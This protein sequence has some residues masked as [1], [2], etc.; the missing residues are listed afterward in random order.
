LPLPVNTRL[1]RTAGQIQAQ[2]IRPNKITESTINATENHHCG[3]S[4]LAARAL[5]RYPRGQVKVIGNRQTPRGWSRNPIESAAEMIQI[6]REQRPPYL[7]SPTIPETATR[8]T[9][10]DVTR[11]AIL[12][13]VI[14]HSSERLKGKHIYNAGNADSIPGV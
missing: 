6:S 1:S 3:N 10:D 11:R 12:T 7:I 2:K 5:S 14:G 9:S 13:L 4:S 8:I